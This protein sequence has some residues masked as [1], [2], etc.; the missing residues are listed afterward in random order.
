MGF[1]F[2]LGMTTL[3]MLRKEHFFVWAW[4]INGSFSVVGSTLVPLLSVTFG[5]SSVIWVSA[6]IYL[7][8]IPCFLRL[9]IPDPV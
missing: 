2:A 3:S 7:A 4:G 1:P 9:R 6:A 8:A 5:I